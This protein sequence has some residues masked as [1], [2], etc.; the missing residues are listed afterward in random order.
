MRKGTEPGVQC[1]FVRFIR[2]NGSRETSSA[3]IEAVISHKRALRKA[4]SAH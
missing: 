2:L 1:L 3:P 4:S